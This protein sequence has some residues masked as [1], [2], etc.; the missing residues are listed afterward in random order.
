[1]GGPPTPVT[2]RGVSQRGHLHRYNGAPRQDDLGLHHLPDGRVI[3]L[4]ADGVSG[5]RNR[6]SVPAPPPSTPPEWLH[7]HLEEDIGWTDWS[8]LLKSTA[9]AINERAQ[10]PSRIIRAGSDPRRGATRDN[11]DLCGPS[12][13]SEMEHCAPYL[14]GCGR[15]GRLAAVGGPICRDPRRQD[16][17][18]LRIASSAVAGLPPR[19]NGSRAGGGRVR[20]MARCC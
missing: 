11:P 18:S 8:T 20:P 3:A 4:V 1:M 2:V 6:I 13:P 17:L 10:E 16:G 12:R 5:R 15:F 7:S 14:V 19:A 9:W